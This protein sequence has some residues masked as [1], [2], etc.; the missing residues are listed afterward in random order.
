MEI[1]GNVGSTPVVYDV[2]ADAL[3]NLSLSI[4]YQAPTPTDPSFSVLAS[5]P[6]GAIAAAA[7][8]GKSAIVGEAEKIFVEACEAYI[9]AQPAAA[10]V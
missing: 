8:A 4:G 5:V 6:M 10:A 9:A 3:L 7:V 2:K 1:K